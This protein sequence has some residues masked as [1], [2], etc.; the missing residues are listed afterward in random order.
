MNYWTNAAMWAAIGAVIGTM[1]IPAMIYLFYPSL[2]RGIRGITGR[3]LWTIGAIAAGRYVVDKESDGNYA[4]R[5]VEE[6]GEGEKDDWKFD[7][8]GTIVRFNGPAN[9]WSRLGKTPFGMVYDKSEAAWGRLADFE[10]ATDGGQTINNRGSFGT[11]RVWEVGENVADSIILRKDSLME[12]FRDAG[13]IRQIR[14]AREIAQ[15]EHG[16]EGGMGELMLLVAVL[17]SLLMGA[18]TALMMAMVA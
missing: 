11:F 4:V 1:L 3:I 9:H 2:P 6:A 17:V 12:R 10:A 13:G 16:G 5:V 14:L 15:R 7:R 8:N 18:G